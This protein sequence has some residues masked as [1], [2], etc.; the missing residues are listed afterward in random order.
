MVLSQSINVAPSDILNT[1]CHEKHCIPSPVTVNDITVLI[2][3]PRLNNTQTGA[4]GGGVGFGW[5]QRLECQ[6]A[7]EG[8]SGNLRLWTPALPLRH[9]PLAPSP[10]SRHS[11]RGPRSDAAG[12]PS[13]LRTQPTGSSM[14][15][16]SILATSLSRRRTLAHIHTHRLKRPRCNQL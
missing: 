15:V 16:G 1:T 10:P 8:P 11:S 6:D 7:G 2:M 14:P 13:L 12:S 9:S 5:S 4:G 3:K